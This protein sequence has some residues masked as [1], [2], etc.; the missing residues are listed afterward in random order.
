MRN[1]N[2]VYRASLY[3]YQLISHLFRRDRIIPIFWK[4]HF[5]FPSQKRQ[6]NLC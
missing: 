5:P 3:Y 1:S 2:S 6:K 4:L